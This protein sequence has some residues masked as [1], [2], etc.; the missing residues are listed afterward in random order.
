[1]F[2]KLDNYLIRYIFSYLDYFEIFKIRNISKNFKI[3]NSNIINQILSIIKFYKSINLLEDE[4]KNIKKF[5]IIFEKNF[6]YSKNSNKFKNFLNSYQNNF[7][8]RIKIFILNEKFCKNKINLDFNLIKNFDLS[9]KINKIKNQ[10]KNNLV[11]IKKSYKIVNCN[12]YCCENIKNPKHN[13]ICI[14]IL[15][16][17]KF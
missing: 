16:Y 11:K 6:V 17:K 7:I 15:F 2:N 9:R 12:Q 14:T 5:K 1:M 10:N 13:I 4:T 8:N 3:V